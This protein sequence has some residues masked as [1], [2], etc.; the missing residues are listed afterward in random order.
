MFYEQVECHKRVLPE[1][2]FNGN[3]IFDEIGLL[4]RLDRRLYA[5]RIEVIIRCSSTG[6][7]TMSCR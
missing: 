3:T 5:L 6:K 1:L 4:V 7:L 2:D